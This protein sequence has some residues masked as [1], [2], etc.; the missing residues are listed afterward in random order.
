MPSK[1]YRSPLPDIDLV[2]SDL[3]TYLFSNNIPADKP[4]FIDA[5]TG[6]T[7]TY[8]DV[9]RRTRSLAHALRNLGVKQHDVVAYYSPNN[10]D[11]GI[12]CYAVI[13]CG[14]IVSPI[15]AASTAPELEALLDTCGARYLIVHSTLIKT[16]Q[17]ATKRIPQI[18]I[19]LADGKKD[20]HGNA[21]AEQLATTN[22]AGQLIAISPQEAKSRIAFLCFSSG[23]TGRSKGVQTSHKNMT[24]NMQQWQKHIPEDW[25]S[26]SINIAFLPFNHIYGLNVYL[27]LALFTGSTVVV[28]SRFDLDLYLSS[29]QKY[30]PKTLFAVPPV[31]LMLAKDP[32]VAKYD[33]KSV[34]RIL[35]AA[36]PLSIELRVALEAR[37][38]QTFGTTVNC[39]Q[40]WGLTE[41]SPFATG[42]EAKR[43]DKKHTV[44]C[45]APN[46]RLRLV[47]AETMEDVPDTPGMQGEIWCSGPNV[48]VGYYKN[49]EATRDGFTTDENGETWFRTGDVAT[50]DS[51]GY[52]TI[53]DRIKE[54]IKYKGLQVIPSELEGKLLQHPYVQ[55][56]AVTGMWIEAQ[57]T[58][59]PVGF[60]V[61]EAGKLA[62]VG[63]AGMVREIH[64]WLAT[65]VAN[66]KRLRGGI[67]PV[68]SVPKSASGKILRRQL[69]EMLKTKKLDA[70]L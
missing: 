45:I 60:V 8:G 39:F 18:R 15:S 24:S 69:K 1:I 25:S 16:A 70:K 50:I 30:R 31:I 17:E 43:I 54:M 33:L 3:L 64:A 26:P 63:S 41:T 48:T 59:V 56:A 11:Y 58:E 36:A 55:D 20:A 42:M 35:S 22:P 5:L 19:I 62:E 32:R 12:C 27:C 68:D 29:I 47:D 23:T 14:A 6:R 49:D 38:L 9:E 21:T 37:F 52:L 67:I 61:F 4:I 46:M 65:R 44:G 10:I 28:M 53:V 34:A 51:D 40:M 7:R 57:A 66:H 2:D 13:G